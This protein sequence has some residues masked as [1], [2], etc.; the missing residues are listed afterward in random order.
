MLAAE[1][2]LRDNGVGEMQT[3]AGTGPPVMF[4]NITRRNIASMILGT[5]VGFGL[6]AT[7]L[8]LALRSLKLGIISLVPN[9]IPAGMAFGVWALTVGEVGFAISMVAGLS[10]GIIV[11]DTVHFLV[12]YNRARQTMSSA[13][14][15]RYAF[16]TVGAAILGN[17]VIV[18][19]GFVMLGLS[20]FRVTAYMGML[21]ALTVVCA[22]IV[23]F[24]LLP[25]LLLVLDRD[26]SPVSDM[27]T[28]EPALQAAGL[29]HTLRR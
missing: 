18:S 28:I 26:R 7:L 24:L 21:T 12:K 2:W 19:A 22:L 1:Q 4:T 5:A 14:S 16:Q 15:V 9:I 25:A 13:D 29:S 3:A 27:K 6:I 11:D 10:I 17:T 8:V 23:D 20:T